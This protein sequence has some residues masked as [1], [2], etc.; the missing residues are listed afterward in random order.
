MR[1]ADAVGK[2]LQR[3]GEFVDLWSYGEWIRLDLDGRLFE[4]A[5][6]GKS[7][8]EGYPRLNALDKS[9]T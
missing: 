3:V 1:F 8:A 2:R 4:A 7:V 9:I 5:R 6:V